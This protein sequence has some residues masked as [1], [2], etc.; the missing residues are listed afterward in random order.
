M[1]INHLER[2]WKSIRWV[3][4]VQHES[5]GEEGK[6]TLNQSMHKPKGTGVEPKTWLN[7]DEQVR[8]TK[9][10]KGKKTEIKGSCSMTGTGV[11]KDESR[12]Q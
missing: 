7:K 10:W 3:Q 4:P 5:E 1:K 11:A 2:E 12:V 6:V 9:I 8:V